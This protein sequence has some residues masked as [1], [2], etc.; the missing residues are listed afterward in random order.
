MERTNTFGSGPL[1]ITTLFICEVVKAVFPSVAEIHEKSYVITPPNICCDDQR[2]RYE[3]LSA[4]DPVTN[5]D[6]HQVK[7][8]DGKVFEPYQLELELPKFNDSGI[9]TH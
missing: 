7:G 4:T 8:C 1:R 3:Q 6:R 9:T 2:W 5:I